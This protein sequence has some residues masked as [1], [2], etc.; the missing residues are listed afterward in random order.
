MDGSTVLLTPR[1]AVQAD[2]LH[3]S[4]RNLTGEPA[5]VGGLAVDAGEGTSG[6]VS[7]T[8]PGKVDVACWPYSQHEERR[9]QHLP[10][11]VA[12]PHGYW[13]SPKLECPGRT[14]SSS[15]LDYFGEAEGE[16]GDPVDIARRS[17]TGLEPE[18][19][20]RRAGYPEAASP[21]VAVVREGRTLVTLFFVAA[22]DGGWLLSTQEACSGTGVR[23]E[24]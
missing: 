3:V 22:R 1:V 12:D 2:G 6:H 21:T 23:W 7:R 13:V 19:V 11:T 8:A 4:V 5:S 16:K 9:P 17:L 15:I 14:A 20:V 18:D 10:M 24:P